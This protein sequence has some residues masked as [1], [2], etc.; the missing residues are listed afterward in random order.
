MAQKAQ[1]DKARRATI[2]A[3]YEER[4]DLS[5]DAIAR[6]A[7]VSYRSVTRLARRHGWRRADGHKAARQ[8]GAET[9]DR[10]ATQDGHAP[11]KRAGDAEAFPGTPRADPM[12]LVDGLRLPVQRHVADLS[13]QLDGGQSAQSLMTTL[14]V[15]EKFT[16]ME[17]ATGA[18]E[19]DH[20][21]PADIDE[22]RAEI[23]RRLEGL[24][25]RR[26]GGGGLQGDS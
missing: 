22:F 6:R 7:G 16:E 13:G 17:T 11:A 26:T 21:G 8:D 14:K 20:E 15:V 4:P 18:A 23:T 19:T 9:Q 24:L 10:A 3:L 1:I 5:L 25:A 12:V 2:R